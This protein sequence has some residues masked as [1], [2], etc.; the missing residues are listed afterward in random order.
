[1][2]HEFGHA[3]GLIHEHQNPD[4]RI[5]WNK[6]AVYQELG[7]PPNRWPR[8]VVD[9]NLFKPW[10]ASE[11]NSTRFDL[12]SIMIYP[13]PARWTIDGFATRANTQLSA[14][15]R[16]FIARV[17]PSPR[18]S[19]RGPINV[20]SIASDD[21]AIIAG[22]NFYPGICHL[23]GAENDAQAFEHWVLS[24]HV[25]SSQVKTI[26]SSTFHPPGLIAASHPSAPRAILQAR[27]EVQQ[28]VEEFH[29]LAMLS[30]SQAHDTGRGP[31]LGRRLYVFFAGH[32]FVPDWDEQITALLAAN[33]TAVV[34]AHVAARFYQ[35]WFIEHG[36]FDEVLLFMDCCSTA[37]MDYPPTRPPL[38]RSKNP[39]AVNNSRWFYATASGIALKTREKTTLRGGKPHGVF[40]ATLLDALSGRAGHRVTNKVLEQYLRDN[41][42]DYLDSSDQ[43]DP[44]IAKE[45]FI[46]TGSGV[47]DI[48]ELSGTGGFPV[49][50]HFRT[51]DVGKSAEIVVVDQVIERTV[52]SSEPWHVSLARG[53]YSVR[54]GERVTVL[55]VRRG[56]Q[57]VDL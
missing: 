2:L 8:S 46:L 45:P 25:P 5:R 15:D 4:A 55:D 29:L 57:C 17:Y 23:L 43:D 3:L 44:Q 35:R 7:A 54:I 40:T 13:I 50:I 31:R 49:E 26:L 33:A 16:E 27:P 6:E 39:V 37:G 56:D 41:M 9:D 52:A 24:Q 10:E 34:P 51:G 30:D 21:Y 53:L 22:L 18:A 1:V 47:F 20:T 42:K 28:L 32:G 36:V 48:V 19:T 38:P 11:T 12:A 14:T